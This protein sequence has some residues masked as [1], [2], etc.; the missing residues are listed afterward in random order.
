MID[1]E[2]LEPGTELG[3]LYMLPHL[4]LTTTL[5]GMCHCLNV[6]N[7]EMES[8]KDNIPVSSLQVSSKFGIGTQICP[9]PK[10]FS[11]HYFLTSYSYPD[12]NTSSLWEF[13]R[14]TCSKYITAFE[15]VGIK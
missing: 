12:G 9:T 14:I 8:Q 5:R 2:L 11:L 1:Q 7:E 15:P 13:A 4:T 6:S 3:L 10:L